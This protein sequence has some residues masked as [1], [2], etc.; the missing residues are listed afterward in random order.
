MSLTE[1][2]TSTVISSG[3]RNGGGGGGEEKEEA[4]GPMTFYSLHR[5]MI[6]VT[7]N[8]KLK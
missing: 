6:F 3:S 2:S 8:S 5:Q 7:K 4:S 1:D